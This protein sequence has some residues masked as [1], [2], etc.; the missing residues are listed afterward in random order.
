MTSALNLNYWAVGVAAVVAFAVGALW[1]SPLLF[2][3][4]RI[5][6][7]GLGS[8]AEAAMSPAAPVAE[9]LRCLVVAFVLALILRIAGVGR[10][11]PSMGLAVLI[12]FGF[13]AALLAGAVIWERMPL[14][15]YAIH[16]GDALIK[17]LLMAA[18]LSLWR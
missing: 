8:G 1:N 17:M 16:T 4:A 13:Q 15:L 10:L 12:W 9:F 7:A 18:I 6:L 5:E 2:G 14:Q 3:A 11:W